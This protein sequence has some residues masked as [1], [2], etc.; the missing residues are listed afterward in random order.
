MNVIGF[1]GANTILTNHSIPLNVNEYGLAA[2][3][4]KFEKTKRKI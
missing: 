2:E 4:G 3:V 1:Y